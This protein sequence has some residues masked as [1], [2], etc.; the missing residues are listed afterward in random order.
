[1]DF[2]ILGPLE[3]SHDGRDVPVAGARRR[4]LLALLLLDAGHVVSTDRLMDE[5]WGEQQ[6]AAGG[7]ALRVRFPQLRKALHAGGEMLVTRAPGYALLVP[8]DGLDLWRFE[9]G[10]DEGE[11]ALASEPRRADALQ[12]VRRRIARRGATAARR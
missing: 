2:R 11:R 10:L 7:T 8:R 12:L 9:R 6:P 4:E 1:M 3:V 5:L